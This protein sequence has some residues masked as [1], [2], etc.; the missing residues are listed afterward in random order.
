MATGCREVIR[1]RIIEWQKSGWT[2][3]PALSGADVILN[4]LKRAGYVIVKD[5][6]DPEG[7]IPGRS[8]T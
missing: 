8:D 3:M 4:D 5:R 1:L 7:G 2:R 6:T